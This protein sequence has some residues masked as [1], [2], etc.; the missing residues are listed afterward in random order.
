MTLRKHSAAHDYW[1]PRVEG[2][3]RDAIKQHPEWFA[4]ATDRQRRAAV[5]SMAKRIV[6]E[7]V[8]CFHD[9]PRAGGGVAKVPSS[10]GSDRGFQVRSDGGGVAHNCLAADAWGAW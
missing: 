10:V 6:G 2:Q 9:A 3:L 8:A 5:N 1:H 4:F 7:I